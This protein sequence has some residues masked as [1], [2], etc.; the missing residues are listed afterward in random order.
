MAGKTAQDRVIYAVG[1]VH[2]RDDLLAALHGMIAERHRAA[3]AGRPG[4]ILHL[5]D[6]ID[7]GPDSRGAVDRVMRG[8][9]G[10]ETACL[11]GNHEAQLLLCLDAVD[12]RPWRAWMKFDAEAALNSFGTSAARIAGDPAALAA[13]VGAERIAWLRALPV[14]HAEGRWFFAHAGVRPGVALGDQSRRDLMWIREEFL[15]SEADHGAVVVHGH[16]PAPAPQLRA[17]R[18]GIDTDAARGGPLTAV[19]LDGAAPPRL[20][21]ARG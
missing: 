20:M 21:Q 6:L 18:I 2:G 17:N 8:V 12:E 4:L 9:E 19:E 10:F 15:R 3:H 1:D 13:V 16:T 7:R 11:M 14:C 5:G